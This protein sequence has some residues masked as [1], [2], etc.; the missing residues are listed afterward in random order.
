[1]LNILRIKQNVQHDGRLPVSSRNVSQDAVRR[2][3]RFRDMRT[4]GEDAMLVRRDLLHRVGSAEPRAME[5]YA[6]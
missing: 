3:P 5:R 2:G 1:M 4:H 6:Q